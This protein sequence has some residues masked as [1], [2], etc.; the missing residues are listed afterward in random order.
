[1]P[2]V[3][4]FLFCNHSR[5][6]LIF[7]ELTLMFELNRSIPFFGDKKAFQKL[8]LST[9]QT[10]VSLVPGDSLVRP[11]VPTPH[12]NQ[13]AVLSLFHS[14]SATPQAEIGRPLAESS[15]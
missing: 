3:I 4:F 9:L 7:Q 11:L 2:V 14:H 5:E 1:M 12:V 15:P 10:I 8:K 6:K 13:Q